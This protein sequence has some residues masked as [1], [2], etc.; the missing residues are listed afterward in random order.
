MSCSK[1]LRPLFEARRSK[2]LSGNC[3]FTKADILG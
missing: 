1:G 2:E 3:M